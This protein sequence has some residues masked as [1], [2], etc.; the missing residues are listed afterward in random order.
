[1]SDIDVAD[2]RR[3]DMNLLVVLG[4]LLSERSATRAG[5]RLGM[6]QAAVSGALARLRT[7]FHDQ[8]FVRAP[9]GLAPTPYA[10]ELGRR[11]TPLLGA[12][13]DVVRDVDS[14]DPDARPRDFV[15][16]MSDDVEA[17]AMPRLVAS[18]RASHPQVRLRV[19][20]TNRYVVGRMLDDGDVDLALAVS[21]GEQPAHRA[22]PLFSSGYVVLFDLAQVAAR[23]PLS[24]DEFL[25]VP[26]V[27][28]SF[29][30]RRGI[31]D[32]A[33]EA[34]GLTRTVATST[35]HFAGAVPLLKAF[36]AF[37]TVPE[38]AG[39]VFAQDAGLAV[40]P[41]P[42]EM[43]PTTVSLIW[44]ATRSGD[45]AHAWLRDRVRE[46]VAQ[47]LDYDSVSAR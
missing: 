7:V 28:I 22:E 13:V 35:T 26:H 47:A 12:L 11:L 37:A 31:V 29:D 40:S 4:A 2:L 6:S 16:G 19:R 38:H 21:A 34:R 24:L 43:T 8:L 1:M 32:D 9:G 3:I 15:L 45:P 27:L 5:R 20:Q 10:L 14:F 25:R 44:H 23:V 17:F 39:R 41:A 42:I 30:G 18:L 46:A 36:P 33:L